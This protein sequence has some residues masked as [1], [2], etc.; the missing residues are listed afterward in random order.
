M[1][2]IKCK[3]C[4]ETNLELFYKTEKSTCKKCRSNLNKDKYKK[5]SYAEKEAYKGYQNIW[6]QINLVRYRF[7]AAR[8]RAR[9]KGQEFSITEEDI[10]ELLTHQDNK[11]FYLGIPF[12]N[13][14]DRYSLSIDRIDSS[15]GYTK[16]NI[17][18]ASSIVNYMKAEYPEEEFWSTVKLL[19]EN[20]F[21]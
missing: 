7:L 9:R 5:M 4:G 12:D 2:E 6:Q 17:R 16:E 11:C 18:L 14:S 3:F 20:H 19:Y 8:Y 10:K 1:K 13:N 21:K 15:K